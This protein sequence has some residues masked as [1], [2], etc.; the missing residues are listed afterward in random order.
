[1]I[2]WIWPFR[3]PTLMEQLIQ[4]EHHP[5]LSP[6]EE[7]LL[8]QQILKQYPP[9]THPIVPDLTGMRIRAMMAYGTEWE[10]PEETALLTAEERDELEWVAIPRRWARVRRESRRAEERSNL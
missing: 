10:N 9:E 4:A 3:R 8:E 5:H 6:E 2:R 1:M 7:E